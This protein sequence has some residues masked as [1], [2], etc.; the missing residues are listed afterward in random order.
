MIGPVKGETPVDKSKFVVWFYIMAN[1][2]FL[3]ILEKYIL[4]NDSPNWGV[5]IGTEIGDF[6]KEKIGFFALPA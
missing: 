1:V 5:Q 6:R 2:N 3:L 4:F